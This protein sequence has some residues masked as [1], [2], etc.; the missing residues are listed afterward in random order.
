M[1]NKVRSLY[2]KGPFYQV[3]AHV[4]RDQTLSSNGTLITTKDL[5]ETRRS[6]SYWGMGHACLDQS[7]DR[8]WFRGRH[9]SP[10]IVC[11]ARRVALQYLHQ[12]RY[13]NL[14]V[15]PGQPQT[16]YYLVDFRWNRGTWSYE[17]SHEMQPLQIR[18]LDGELQDVEQ[19]PIT[20]ARKTLGV[21]LAPDGSNTKEFQMLCEKAQTWADNIQIHKL[22]RKFAWQS[23]QSTIMAQLSY[24]LQATTMSPDQC[25]RIDKII[26][27]AALPASGM[28]RTFPLGLAYGS[29]AHQGLG[30][31]GL[32]DRQGIAAVIASVKYLNN[33]DHLVGQQLK[34]SIDVM[35]IEIGHD[36]LFFHLPYEDWNFLATESYVKHIW[37]YASTHDIRIEGPKKRWSRRQGDSC[38]IPHFT[39]H[40]GKKDLL[41]LNRCRLYIQAMTLSDIVTTDGKNFTEA[42]WLGTKGNKPGWPNQGP[43]PPKDWSFW[44]TALHRTFGYSPHR[45]PTLLLPLGPWY[46]EETHEWWYLS[47]TKTLY[48]QAEGITSYNI[49]DQ[50]A[51]RSREGEFRYSG[52]SD[53]IPIGAV[54]A[55]I[56]MAEGNVHLMGTTTIEADQTSQQPTWWQQRQEETP[57]D[58]GISIIQNILDG[59]ARAVA[60]GSFKDGWGTASGIILGSGENHHRVDV[61]TPGVAQDQCSFRSELSGILAIILSVNDLVISH[62]AQSGS[63]TVACD[64]ESAV[65]A[66]NNHHEGVN[67]NAC[68][69]D[70]VTAVRRNIRASPIKWNFIHVKGHATGD[71]TDWEARNHEMDQA[72]KEYWQQ[73]TAERSTVQ[74]FQAEE[75]SLTVGERKLTS[76]AHNE[77][78]QWAQR[79]HSTTYWNKRMSPDATAQVDWK[80][81]EAAMKRLPQHRRIWIAKQ[82]SGMF[83][84]GVRMVD[85]NSRTTDACPCCG[86][87]ETS[88]HILRCK[89]TESTG[90]WN[91]KLSELREWMDEEQTDPQLRDALTDG[92]NAWRMTSDEELEQYNLDHKN[93]PPGLLDVARNSPAAAIQTT[94]GWRAALEGRI[95]VAWRNQQADFW[96]GQNSRKSPQRWASTLV[97][98]ILAITWEIWS[99]RNNTLHNSQKQ[100]ADENINTDITSLY[101]AGSSHLPTRIQFLFQTP[102]EELLQKRAQQKVDWLTSVRAATQKEASHR[103]RSAGSRQI[104]EAFI[105]NAQSDK[106][107]PPSKP[108]PGTPTTATTTQPPT[109]T[110][111]PEPPTPVQRPLYPIFRPR[112]ETT[113]PNP[114]QTTGAPALYPIFRARQRR[115]LEPPQPTNNPTQTPSDEST[116]SQQP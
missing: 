29:V 58:E 116:N 2:S 81:T 11:H 84:S 104:M 115:T 26:R 79:K 97:S 49:I 18:N 95:G 92:L 89:Q 76:A 44:Q 38:I 42:C 39:E 74:H 96:I 9:Y 7:L 98:K 77:L 90:I 61:I 4:C 87:R 48:H 57:A 112:S 30:M 66:S 25:A 16:F 20:E 34:V 107:P 5:F 88:E 108:P 86:A 82:S 13:Q 35:T 114:P 70:L 24:P 91:T 100:L 21:H 83:A 105:R 8:S 32:Y 85:R 40:Y 60:D 52:S 65:R 111:Q 27:Q 6:R 55:S 72:C 67:T 1:G 23:L 106:V 71:L 73:T 54:P 68:H 102:L 50:R 113:A 64:N 28:L 33:P 10:A 63:I 94:I 109:V 99:H 93:T 53:F 110:T 56:R 12:Q 47:A 46:P 62:G 41:R 14:V 101:E 78:V 22:S 3:F 69:F 45:S 80:A 51:R 37:K 36:D 17:L 103:R 31:I 75:W 59:T 15:L 19:V 43:L